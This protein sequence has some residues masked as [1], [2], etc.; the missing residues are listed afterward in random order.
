MHSGAN[1]KI[2]L[3]L[4]SG[5]T[6]DSRQIEGKEAFHSQSI[7]NGLSAYLAQN[8]AVHTVSMIAL[9]KQRETCRLSACDDQ[10]GFA[11]QK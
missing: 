7:A 4:F 3:A 9:C 8:Y 11:K 6:S 10:M 2:N 5:I 1:I